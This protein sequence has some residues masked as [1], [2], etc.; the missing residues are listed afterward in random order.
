MAA[1]M[2]VEAALP[3]CDGAG[4]GS[5]AGAGA[6]AASSSS[7]ASGSGWEVVAGSWAEDW[8]LGLGWLDCSWGAGADSWGWAAACSACF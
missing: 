7:A 5:G 8:G 3:E 6:G 2:A 1:L 4:A